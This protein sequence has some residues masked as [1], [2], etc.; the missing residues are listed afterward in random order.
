MSD[1]HLLEVGRVAKSHGLRGE[2]VVE[3]FTN[4]LE[5]VAPGA[6]LQT[7]AETLTVRRAKPF[8]HRWLV[9][10]DGVTSRNAADALHGK[11]LRAAPIDDPNVLWVHELIGATVAE[12]DGTA[13]GHIIGVIDNP[14]GDLLELDSG[15][16]VPLRFV[17]S[18][19]NNIVIIDVPDGLF[20]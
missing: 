15:A 20:D 9:Q 7:D 2:V 19:E 11:T 16:L 8:Q 4:R 14:A 17:V 10:F 6:V 12:A 13:R 5:R 3:L 1:E 18:F